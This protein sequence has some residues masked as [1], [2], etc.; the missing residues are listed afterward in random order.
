[1]GDRYAVATG[2]WA[3][4]STWSDTSG[5]SPGASA[6]VS[7]DTAYLNAASGAITVTVAANAACTVLDCSGYSGTLTI[8]SSYGL[9]VGGNITLVSGMTC[10]GTGT[11]EM[12]AAG[13]L[14][15]GGVSVSWKL[16][17]TGANT[18]TLNTNGTKWVTVTPTMGGKILTLSSAFQCATLDLTD[19][20]SAQ[21]GGAYDISCDNF[22]MRGYRQQSITFKAGQALNISSKINLSCLRLS[23]GHTIKSDTSSSAFYINYSGTI[24]ECKVAGTIFTDIDASGSAVPLLNWFGGT[25]TR[26][27]NIY[28]LSGENTT[29]PA[30]ADVKSG[31]EYGGVDDA[32]VKRLTGTYAGGGSGG[33]P[34]MGG[35]VVR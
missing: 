26:T 31:V 15:S 23:D 8:N 2:N 35:M 3:S 28:N 21:F 12:S 32:S 19:W 27:S 13:T 5:G 10:S 4:T 30:V 34:V 1:M 7:G 33:G 9:T 17:L 24:A 29:I 16:S 11:L 14:T 18:K 20:G 6:P 22:Y 25:L